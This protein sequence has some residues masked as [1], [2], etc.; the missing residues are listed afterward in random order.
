MLNFLSKS[1]SSETKNASE[2]AA[3]AAESGITNEK[4]TE[5]QIESVLEV[6][7]Y[8]PGTD[9]EKKLVRK[10][11]LLL[12]PCIFIMYFLSYLD[13]I[14]V[15]NA[16]V[17]GM[18]ADLHL[19]SGQYSI[20]LI[21]AIIFYVS[22]EIPTNMILSKTRPSIFLGVI[23]ITWGLITLLIWKI[24][25]YPELVGM[26]VLV[27]L[28]EA[29]FA[30]GVLLMFSSWY[31]RNEQS[32]RFGIYISAPVLAGAFGGL[33]AGAITTNLEDAH[34]IPGWRWLF[35]V[36]GSMTIGFAFVALLVL[37]DFPTKTRHM[38]ERERKLAIARLQYDSIVNRR[39]GEP[40]VTH[41][42]ALK[43]ALWNWRT[44]LFATGYA[45]ITGTSS[46]SYFYP[47]LMGG[48]GYTGNRVQYM[49]VP[50]YAVAFVCNLCT[51][52]F[53]DRKLRPYRGY[54]TAAWLVVLTVCSIIFTCVYNNTAR[55][56]LLV[57]MTSAVWSTTAATLAYAS[58]SYSY[59]PHEARAIALAFTNGFGTSATIYGAFLFPA[60]DSPKYLMAFSLISALSFLGIFVF[61]ALQILLVRYP[62]KF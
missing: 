57:F 2:L 41:L 40:D 33:L 46:M 1:N 36:E 4:E 51:S 14:N 26:R 29:G 37:L 16:K 12:L 62:G 8:R 22:F 17:A 50:L 9:E 43:I 31:K 60:K 3:T 18:A 55:Y 25:T 48:L 38:N 27:G 45:I 10:I 42:Q 53:S 58:S 23:M 7:D 59:M 49:T 24:K 21:V 34:G 13:R 44:L 11:D 54:V 19:S 32:M 20:V 61:L 5:H 52:Y 6:P 28:A 30:P 39:E 15:G 35:I 47:T 56:V